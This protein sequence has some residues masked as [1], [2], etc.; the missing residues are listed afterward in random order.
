VKLAQNSRA[1]ALVALQGAVPVGLTSVGPV[2]LAV[3]ERLTA[4]LLDAVGDA[5]ERELRRFE[6]IKDRRLQVDAAALDRAHRGK[7]VL[8]T[9]GTGCIGSSLLAELQT[10]GPGQ[11]VSFSRGVTSHW[12]VVDDVHYRFVDIRDRRKLLTEVGDLQP[13]IV[14]HLAAQHNPGLAEFE[15]ARTLST[16]VTGTVNVV[17]AC[18]RSGARMVYSSTGKALRPFS[19]DVYA[20]S[21]KLSEWLVAEATATGDLVA[22]AARFTHVVDNSIIACRFRDWTDSGT[23]LRLHGPD[24]S[25]YLQ[26]A[27]EAAQL[28]MCA[29]VDAFSGQLRLGAIRDL[30]WPIELTE[31]ALGWL[32]GH[33]RKSPIYFCGFEAGYEDIPYPAL[34][35]PRLSGDRSPLLNAFEVASA[36]GSAHSTDVD[37]C[38]ITPRR[39]PRVQ[40]LITALGQQ[41]AICADPGVLRGLLRECGWL[42]LADRLESVPTSVL[43]RHLEFVGSIPAARFGVDDLEVVHKA[44]AEMARRTPARTPEPSE[45]DRPQVQ[46]SSPVLEGTGRRRL[47]GLRRRLRTTLSGVVRAGGGDAAF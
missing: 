6:A 39:E 22:S 46:R 25:F 32:S 26:S 13:D 23:P 8:V 5:G 28:L 16:N 29:G 34:Y 37:L 17:E 33:D 30:G 36:T 47:P 10:F 45:I 38:S 43:A 7:T 20:A 3:L 12:T 9:G 35:D 15:V 2:D 14:Y 18:R 31:L 4:D 27:G 40:G 44:R 1:A 21:K 19:S 42:M 41:A 11:L 24:I